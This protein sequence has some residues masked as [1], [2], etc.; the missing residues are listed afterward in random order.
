MLL[1]VSEPELSLKLNSGSETETDADAAAAS[2]EA[3]P[4]GL[5]LGEVAAETAG[6]TA[7]AEEDPSGSGTNWK[8]W[9]LAAV[10]VAQGIV[11]TT[12][13]VFVT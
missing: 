10:W 6:V 5:L 2:P 9:R 3:G 12:V 13:R 1:G 11:F 8:T 4:A 7:E